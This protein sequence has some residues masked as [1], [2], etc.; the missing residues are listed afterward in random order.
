MH[1]SEFANLELRPFPPEGYPPPLAY[2]HRSEA[3]VEAI[4][5]YFD[6]PE[7]SIDEISIGLTLVLIFKWLAVEL[8]IIVALLVAGGVLLGVW[9]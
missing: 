2:T 3:E 1:R 6:Q 9:N 5:R 7:P 8:A 4:L